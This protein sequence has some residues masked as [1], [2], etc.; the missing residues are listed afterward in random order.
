MFRSA[1]SLPDDVE[2]SQFYVVGGMQK[3]KAQQRE[4]SDR[5]KNG[6]VILLDPQEGRVVRRL[7]YVSPPHVRPDH[8]TNILFKAATL[9]EDHLYL[10][11]ETEVL[12]Y[13]EPDLEQ[14][15]YVSLPIFNDLHHVRPSPRGTLLVV[16]TGLD[17][18]AEVSL[19]GE[20]LTHWSVI[21]EDPWRRFSPDVD[22]RKVPSTQPHRAHPNYV[23][24]FDGETWAT[25]FDQRDAISLTNGRRRI[26][27]EVEAPHDGHVYRGKVYFTTVDG[28]VVVTEGSTSSPSRVYDLNT[29][30]ATDGPLGWC[31]G[32]EIL[33]E[34]YVL[35][36]FSRLRPTRL[37]RNV[38]WVR[39]RFRLG[40]HSEHLPTRV[41]LFDLERERQIWEL[42]LE[43]FG[44]NGIFSIHSRH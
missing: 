3:P 37:R 13:Q 9:E 19:D 44:M 22:W 5:Y 2:L 42:D 11:T 18:V 28:H 16:V 21:D 1:D 40:S 41:C 14:V 4:S 35:V 36:G 29:F 15:A 43:D 12:V 8:K 10:C 33:S 6:L 25:R 38:R 30:V 34:R 24:Y 31:R 20:L 27:V 7:E 26:P 23:F 32:L 39:E 17:M